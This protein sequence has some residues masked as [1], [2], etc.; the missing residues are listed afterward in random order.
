M[1]YERR[2]EVVLR[3]REPKPYRRIW[4][5]LDGETGELLLQRW[6]DDLAVAFA[7]GE[8][9]VHGEMTVIRNLDPDTKASCYGL[10]TASGFQMTAWQAG[11]KPRRK[12]G[13]KKNYMKLHAEKA[14]ELDDETALALFRLANNINSR[15]EVVDNKRHRPLSAAGIGKLWGLQRSQAF[16]RLK[17]LKEAGVLTTEDGK[18][19]VNKVYLEKT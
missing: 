17:K 4:E 9:L 1:A 15:G 14:Q 3:C 12:R 18:Y 13:G 6:E 19:I 8:T 7:A 10:S 2:L 16:A 11:E 5:V